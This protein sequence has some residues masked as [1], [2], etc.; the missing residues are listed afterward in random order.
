M[1]SMYWYHVVKPLACA[2]GVVARDDYCWVMA[3]AV[4]AAAAVAD[5]KESKGTQIITS[6]RRSS[7]ACIGARSSLGM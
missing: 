1:S 6:S 5:G 7:L 4:A 2:G 3:L